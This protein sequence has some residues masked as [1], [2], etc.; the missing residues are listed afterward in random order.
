LSA[1]LFNPRDKE[2]AAESGA[3]GLLQQY[4]LLSRILFA[5]GNT[6]KPVRWRTDW[7][8]HQLPRSLERSVSV[9]PTVDSSGFSDRARE[10]SNQIA[11]LPI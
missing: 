10:K 11:A 1:V 9:L 3:Q 7:T 4:Q 8:I 6:L 2:F 5:L